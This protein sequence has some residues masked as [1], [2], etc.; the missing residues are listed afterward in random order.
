MRRECEAALAGDQQGVAIRR[1]ACDIAGAQRRA[2]AWDALTPAEQ[3]ALDYRMAVYAAQVHRM[4]WNVGRFVATLREQGKLE[5]TLIIF[6]SDNGGCAEPYTDLGGQAAARI[7]DP[8]FSG[9]VS[10]GTGWAN[11]SNTP[12]RKFKSM[13]HEGG[14][15]APPR[16]LARRLE[17]E[18]RLS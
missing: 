2:R 9:P 18:T 1:S 10:Y 4:D 13:L 17:N 7:N 11:A 5:N 14:I 6:L 15:S 16:P 8:D 3:T 12:F